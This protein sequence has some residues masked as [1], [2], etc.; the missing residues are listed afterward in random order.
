MKLKPDQLRLIAT[1]LE[2]LAAHK[3]VRLQGITTLVIEWEGTPNPA[4]GHY[5]LLRLGHTAPEE[6]VGETHDDTGP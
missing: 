6:K 5:K 4:K 3:E 1:W 2:E